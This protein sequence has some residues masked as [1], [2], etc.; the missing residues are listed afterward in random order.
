MTKQE[1]RQHAKIL[2]A[3]LDQKALGRAMA[4]A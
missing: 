2:R 3:A 1:V 4:D